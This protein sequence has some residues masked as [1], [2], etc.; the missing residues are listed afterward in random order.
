[1]LLKYEYSCMYTLS[2]LNCRMGCHRN[3]EISLNQNGFIIEEH[4]ILPY[5]PFDINNKCYEF[6]VSLITPWGTSIC[7]GFVLFFKFS[8]IFLIMHIR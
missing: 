4:I 8:L 2:L 5:E 3:Y 7:N 6:N 1:M